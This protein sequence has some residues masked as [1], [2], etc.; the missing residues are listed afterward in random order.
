MQGPVYP[1]P[2]AGALTV[3]GGTVSGDD[4]TATTTTVTT[5]QTVQPLFVD[6]SAG[7][8]VWSA[9]V[10]ADRAITSAT[11]RKT[12]SPARR[13]VT[14]GGSPASAILEIPAGDTPVTLTVVVVC[15]VG[16]VLIVNQR[17]LQAAAPDVGILL[18]D[19][20]F[21]EASPNGVTPPPPSAGLPVREAASPARRSPQVRAAQAE[22]TRRPDLMPRQSSLL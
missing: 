8:L 1:Q 14:R 3:T 17:W 5:S 10:D 4:I 22:G 21:G 9:T 6:G 2:P 18:A 12:S 16:T 13:S 19:L 20:A 7:R 15:P 11:F